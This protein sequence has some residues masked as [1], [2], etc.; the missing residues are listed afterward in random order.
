M[1]KKPASTD[2]RDDK[3]A[4]AAVAKFEKAT[5]VGDQFFFYD[6]WPA[7]I[8]HSNKKFVGPITHVSL[9]DYQ[10]NVVFERNLVLTAFAYLIVELTN[11][12]NYEATN[13]SKMSGF[14]IEIPGTR[15]DFLKMLVD[16]E[17]HLKKARVTFEKLSSLRGGDDPKK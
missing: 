11:T 12:L 13:L 15:S 6:S 5:E 10:G 16:A 7:W 8:V 1:T 4:D 2:S 9:G 14:N 17:A 3:D